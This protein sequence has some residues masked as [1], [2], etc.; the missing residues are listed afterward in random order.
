LIPCSLPK[1]A[2]GCH[3]ARN[4]TASISATR[5]WLSRRAFCF[6][7]HCPRAEVVRVYAAT[8][9]DPMKKMPQKLFDMVEEGADQADVQY[10]FDYLIQAEE[11]RQR[12][13]NVYQADD[14]SFYSTNDLKQADQQLKFFREKVKKPV[15]GFENRG[16][17]W[18]ERRGASK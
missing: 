8:G 3:S 6:P 11:Q 5:R 13:V 12:F 4:A 18:H 10:I 16:D 9:D 17:T 2:S 15:I 1:I 14:I 7:I